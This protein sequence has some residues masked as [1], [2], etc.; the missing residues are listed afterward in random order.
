LQGRYDEA[1]EWFAKSRV[2][3][4]EQGARPLRAIVDF[5]E[6]LMEKRRGAGAGLTRQLFEA[7][8]RQFRELQMTGWAR[9]ASE[10]LNRNL[11]G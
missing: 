9:V 3:L 7:A 8:L 1:G 11:Q 10:V 6:A 5:D 2:V 4:D